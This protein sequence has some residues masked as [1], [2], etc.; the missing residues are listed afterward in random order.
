MNYLLSVK[1]AA[2]ET[3]FSQS[4]VRAKI[5]SGELRKIKFGRA[6]RVFSADI[7]RLTERKIAVTENGVASPITGTPKSETTQ[8]VMKSIG[9]RR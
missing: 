6:V 1:D 2:K 4:W 3:G 9:V 5:R 7:Q 8:V